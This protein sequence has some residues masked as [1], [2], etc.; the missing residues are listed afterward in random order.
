MRVAYQIAICI[1]TKTAQVY[2]SA[3]RTI[4]NL[5]AAMLGVKFTF[6]WTVALQNF[7]TIQEVFV[8]MQVAL[9]QATLFLEGW[10]H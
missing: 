10:L 7:H 3:Q 4:Q 8:L 9:W 2:F 5:G 6:Q 1:I